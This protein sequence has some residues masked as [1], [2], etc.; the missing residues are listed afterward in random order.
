MLAQPSKTDRAALLAKLGEIQRL[1]DAPSLAPPPIRECWHRAAAARKQ[2]ELSGFPALAKLLRHPVAGFAHRAGLEPLLQ[3]AEL[4]TLSAW[5]GLVQAAV[6]FGADVSQCD[7]LVM[8]L[9]ELPWLPALTEA[10]AV[11]TSNAISAELAA[12]LPATCSDA[13][14]LAL[15]AYLLADDVPSEHGTRE[16]RPGTVALAQTVDVA[17]A[18]FVCVMGDVAEDTPLTGPAIVLGAD[19]LQP[20]HLGNTA[21]DLVLSANPPGGEPTVQSMESAFAQSGTGADLGP[22]LLGGTV[23]AD[24]GHVIPG[25]TS[26]AVIWIAQDELQLTQSAISDRILPGLLAW[27]SSQ[28]EDESRQIR[29]DLSYQISLIGNAMELLG[30]PSLGE[31]LRDMERAIEQGTTDAAQIIGANAAILAFLDAPAPDTAVL[32]ISARA[33]II[34]TGIDWEQRFLEESGRIRQGIDPARIAARKRSVLSGDTDLRHA[35]DVLPNVLASML[36]ELPGNAQR[37]GAAVREL[38]VT[39]SAAPIDEARRIAHTLKGDANTVGIRGLANLTHALEDIL[40]ELLKAPERLGANMETLLMEAADA[41]EECAD[42]VL[43]R[44]PAPVQLEQIYQRALDWANSLL[45]ATAD[46]MHP[47]QGAARLSEIAAQTLTAEVPEDAGEEAGI[48]SLVVQASLL[49]ELQRMAGEMLVTSRQVTQRLQQMAAAQRDLVSDVGVEHNLANQLDDLVAL[50]GAALKSASMDSTSVVDALELDQYNELHVVSRRIMETNLDNSEHAR[51]MHALLADLDE[52]MVEQERINDDLQ[53]CVGKTRTTPFRDIVPRLQRV[54]RQTARQL[55]R[56]A[57]LVVVGETTALD[58]ALLE[59]LVEPLSHVLRNAIDHGLEDPSQRSAAGKPANGTIRVEVSIS[60]DLA[61]VEVSDDGR[62]L[63]L[64]RIRARAEQQ[65][66]VSAQDTLAPADL[67]RLILAPGF[68]T[69]DQVTQISG[70]GVGMDVVN[71]RVAALR[72]SLAIRSESGLGVKVSIRLPLSQTSANVIVAHGHDLVVAVAA[73][74]VERMQSLVADDIFTG[75]EGALFVELD[76]QHLPAVTLESLFGRG[77]YQSLPGEGSCLGLVV[78]GVD[79]KRRVVCA[80]LVTEVVRVVVK[81]ISSL[82]PVIPAVRGMTQLGDGQIAPVIDIGALVES[83]GRQLLPA[84]PTSYIERP[85]TVVVADDSLSVRRA[86]E[87]LMQDAGYEVAS[88]RDGLEALKHINECN[89]VAV[90]LDL[91]MPRMSGLDVCKYMRSQ[92]QMRNTPVVM[93]TSR[94]S[95]KYRTMAVEAGVTELLGKPFAE[96]QLV[97]LVRTLV[98]RSQN[99]GNRDANQT[100]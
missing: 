87:Q 71:Q 33:D 62:G 96:D 85:P 6:E 32:V 28:S 22:D 60:G 31:L 3:T 63:D 95:D 12:A 8:L 50:R 40:I 44:G 73:G 47:P 18:E 57:G 81:P 65:G 69:R 56:D 92:S 1:L 54:V 24:V 100:F 64:D 83:H 59:R 39:R 23:F 70:R 34:C 4:S 42:H 35:D 41:V 74:A 38:A 15:T 80:R 2:C 89:P 61:L 51:R 75:D 20:R 45:E 88:A 37:L 91:E 84:G 11:A 94:A 30:T 77:G 93:I 52:L 17:S 90:L 25:N 14:G 7:L 27:A 99:V 21:N 79:G 5:Y 9:A 68:S 58:A 78:V 49:D 43:G 29:D 82:L 76:G 13:K 97:S 86:L 67:S 19:A 10:Q 36:R 55:G 48:G 98:S 26:A 66:L 16:A 46:P 72:G 53:R